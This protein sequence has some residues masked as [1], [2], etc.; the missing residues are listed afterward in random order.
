MTWL[1]AAGRRHGAGRV[2]GIFPR[3]ELKLLSLVIA[4]TLW[5]FVAAGERGEMMLA[6]RVEYL[7][8]PSGLMLE[9]SPPETVDVQ[10]QGL[11]PALRRLTVDDVRVQVNVARLGPGGAMVPL[12]PDQVQAPR[13][14]TVLRVNPT[15]VRLTLERVATGTVRVVPRLTGSPEPGYAVAGVSVAPPTVEVRGP[16]SEVAGHPAVPTSPVD[17]SG[18]TAPITRRTELAPALGAVRLT[19]TRSVDVT[20]DIRDQR[21]GRPSGAER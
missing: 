11:R 3:W 6:A 13:D 12:G 14:V 15:R 7:N 4:F 21:T 10:V 5:L 17:I 18:A 8:V 16:Q 2:R 20:V 1:G 9:G 19:T